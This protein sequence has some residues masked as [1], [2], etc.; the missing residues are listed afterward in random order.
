MIQLTAALAAG[1]EK[2]SG[3]DLFLPPLYDLFWSVVVIIPIAIVIYKVVV[4]RFTEVLDAR[5]AKIEG[6]IEHARIVQE[7]ADASLAAMQAKLSDSHSQSARLR[8]AA[9]AEGEQ[10]IAEARSKANLEAARI[11]A[12][13]QQQIAAERVAAEVALRSHLGSL[14]TLLAGKLVGQELS[15]AAAQSRVID[16]FLD[17]LEAGVVAETKA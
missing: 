16:R 10:I 7:Q 11:M 5:T 3:V 2:V 9:R 15:D 14:A 8:E 17:E 6:G 4:P 13:A 12:N 1:G